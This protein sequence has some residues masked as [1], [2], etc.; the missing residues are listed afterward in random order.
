MPD[1]PDAVHLGGAQQQRPT[2]A[3]ASRL[4]EPRAQNSQNVRVEQVAAYGLEAGAQRLQQ[5]CEGLGLRWLAWRD[6]AITGG[7]GNREFFLQAQA[8]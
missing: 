2:L 8:V 4:G 1:R 3:R 6:S 7:D 5:A